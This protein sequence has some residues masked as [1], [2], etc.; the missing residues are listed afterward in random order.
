MVGPSRLH[1]LRTDA[2][3]LGIDHVADMDGSEVPLINVLHR[4]L[5]EDRR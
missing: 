1:Q 5:R 2:L 3:R 4:S